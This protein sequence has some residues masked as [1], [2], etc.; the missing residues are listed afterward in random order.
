[1]KQRTG[2]LGLSTDDVPAGQRFDY[3]RDMYCEPIG[4]LVEPPQ[5]P[6]P[7]SAHISK[8]PVGPLFHIQ[9]RQDTPC[10][11]RRTHREIARCP[12]DSITIRREASAGVQINYP[13]KEF[14]VSAGD[15]LIADYDLPFENYPMDA[16]VQHSFWK[17]PKAAVT[18]YCS[19]F[20]MP[21]PNCVHATDAT[22]RLLSAYLDRLESELADMAPQTLARVS[23]HLCRLIAIV[24][25]AT[26]DERSD[27]VRA[28][29]LAQ[30]KQYVDRHLTEHDLSPS[31][32]ASALG[33]SVRSLHLAFE[34]EDTTVARYILRRRLEECRST[35]LSDLHRPIIDIAFAWG[36]NSLSGFY[37]AFQAAFDAAPGDLRAT[38]L[39]SAARFPAERELS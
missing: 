35:L 8:V 37:R 21:L 4:L 23:D 33:I 14:V 20:G 10:V 32:I 1:L 11:V 5:G 36:F 16:T 17:I 18:P 9:W 27:G 12:S 6:A 2:G 22:S 3:W 30:V 19:S 29:R 25:G 34:S 39:I 28:A 38:T 15:M 24:L 26:V 7:F 13:G 31:R